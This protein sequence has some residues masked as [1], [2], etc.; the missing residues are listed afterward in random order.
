M[1]NVPGTQGYERVIDGFIELSQSLAFEDLN[2]VFLEFLPTTA[3]RVLDAGAGAGQNAAAM[4]KR[5]H[6]VIAV[7]PLTAFLEAA[8]QSYADP[9]ITWVRDSLPLLEKLGDAPAQF[10]FIL[11][12]GVWHHLD[13]RERSLAMERLSMLLDDG[14][15]CAFTL[16]N[17]PAGGGTRVFPT[18]GPQTVSLAAECGLKTVLHRA[19]QPSYMKNKPGVI[20]TFLVVRKEP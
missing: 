5:G 10:D 11:I 19:D 17:G 7:E 16:R 1:D 9:K 14:G 20:W 15:A 18:D 4:A 13:E 6:S 12:Q 2:K 3:G 8:R